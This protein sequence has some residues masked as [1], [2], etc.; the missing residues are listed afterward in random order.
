MKKIYL[1]IVLTNN[2]FSYS[3]DNCHKFEKDEFEV[4]YIKNPIHLNENVQYQLRNSVQWQ[5]FLN[6]NSNW[7]VYFNEYNNLLT[8]LLEKVYILI[9]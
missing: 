6:E 3:H 8:G 5:S 9:L 2:L 4:R 7:F 1:V